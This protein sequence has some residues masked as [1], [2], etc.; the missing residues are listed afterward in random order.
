MYVRAYLSAPIVHPVW[1]VC[2]A[3]TTWKPISGRS[4][5]SVYKLFYTLK[6]VLIIDKQGAYR[7]IH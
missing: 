4:F 5:S 1:R 7:K 2:V 3:K 6:T